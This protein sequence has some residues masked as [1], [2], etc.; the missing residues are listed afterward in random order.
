M[1]RAHDFCNISA[2]PR[3]KYRMSIDLF[4]RRV[5]LCTPTCVI[6]RLQSCMSYFSLMMPKRNAHFRHIVLL[7]M[8]MGAP[9][10]ASTL[11][12]NRVVMTRREKWAPSSRRDGPVIRLSTM[13][14]WLTLII[15]ISLVNCVQ[16]WTLLEWHETCYWQFL[17]AILDSRCLRCG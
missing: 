13:P 7:Y 1:S 14:W 4:P 8:L 3:Y 15:Y 16:L 5:A 17:V 10:R 9:Q 11:V 2:S 6:D 12:I